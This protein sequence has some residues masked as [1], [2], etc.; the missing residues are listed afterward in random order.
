MENDDSRSYLQ[1]KHL[2]FTRK[3]NKKNVFDYFQKN[4]SSF[5]RIFPSIMT[6]GK[7]LINIQ[8]IN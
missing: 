8:P 2:V 6:N 5:K 7:N 1:E 3:S 4:T